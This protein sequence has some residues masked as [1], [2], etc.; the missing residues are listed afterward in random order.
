M[1]KCFGVKKVAV[2]FCLLFVSLFSERAFAQSR[3]TGIGVFAGAR[4]FGNGDS[5]PFLDN[6]AYR[7]N[8]V[9]SSGFEGNLSIGS[10]HFGQRFWLAD[11]IYTGLHGGLALISS[12]GVRYAPAAYFSVGAN[13]MCVWICLSPELSSG[14]AINTSSIGQ[15]VV[16]LANY[17][18]GITLWW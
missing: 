6:Y 8:W 2:V 3:K 9:T 1:S 12:R 17:G 13:P 18:I 15:R 11:T 14:F 10:V 4:T 5:N 7:L 16:P